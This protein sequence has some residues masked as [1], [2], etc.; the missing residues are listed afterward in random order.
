MNAVA[1][2]GQLGEIRTNMKPVMFGRKKDST[3]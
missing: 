2:I 3:I 1:G